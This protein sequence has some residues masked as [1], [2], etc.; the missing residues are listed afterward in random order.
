MSRPP[1][2]T[3]HEAFRRLA[4]ERTNAVLEKVRILANCANPY[5]YEWT[6]DD[7]RLIFDAIAREVQDAQTRF[8]L[9]RR[10]RGIFSLNGSEPTAPARRAASSLDGRVQIGS[11]EPALIASQPAANPSPAQSSRRARRPP[12]NPVGP[13][14]GAFAVVSRVLGREKSQI[15]IRLPDIPGWRVLA[16]DRGHKKG[17][18]LLLFGPSSQGGDP[19]EVVNTGPGT[20]RFHAV[21][22][23]EQLIAEHASLFDDDRLLARAAAEQLIQ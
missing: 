8:E 17:Y 21:V 5:A 20:L 23:G 19:L 3:K 12:R 1:G 7:V 11:S 14:H 18:Q 22:R 2:E 6:D 4:A 9:N 10:S 15:E 13:A 16:K